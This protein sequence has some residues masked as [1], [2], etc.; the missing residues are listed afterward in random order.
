[1]AAMVHLRVRLATKE[2]ERYRELAKAQGLTL[3]AW[4]RRIL[5]DDM[6]LK[7]FKGKG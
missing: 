2:K 3:S 1:M 4:V 5:E 7:P 6:K